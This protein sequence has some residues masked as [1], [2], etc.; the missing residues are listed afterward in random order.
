[1][2]KVSCLG[3]PA[4]LR[5]VS[6]IPQALIRGEEQTPTDPGTPAP[7]E[8][9]PFEGSA[10]PLDLSIDP[11][12][13]AAAIID[14]ETGASLLPEP[15]MPRPILEGP[16]TAADIPVLSVVEAPRSNGST[17]TDRRLTLVED[18]PEPAHPVEASVGPEEDAEC[19]ADFDLP[20]LESDGYTVRFASASAYR[21]QYAEHI[22]H[23]GMVVAASALPIGTQRML[24]LVVPVVGTYTVSARVVFHTE[25]RLGFMLDSFGIHRERLKAMAKAS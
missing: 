12:L 7:G 15:T 23:G 24:S 13:F 9:G 16:A 4:P 8:P 17:F 6:S 21:A 10:T 5:P 19:T 3:R 22:S 25:G 11:E 14:D 18:E 2:R 20:R 1:M